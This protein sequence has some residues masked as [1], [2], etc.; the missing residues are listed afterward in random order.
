MWSSGFSDGGRH[1][2]FELTRRRF[3]GSS[4]DGFLAATQSPKKN[5]CSTPEG[6]GHWADGSDELAVNGLPMTP[7]LVVFIHTLPTVET[8]P[9]PLMSGTASIW[10]EP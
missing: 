2:V 9:G 1:S 4:A 6:P 3:A 7:M 10:I 5:R 8:C